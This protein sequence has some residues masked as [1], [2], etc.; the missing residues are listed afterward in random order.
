MSSSTGRGS[1]Q[2]NPQLA[3]S[4]TQKLQ[5]PGTPQRVSVTLS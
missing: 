1:N 3:L 2:S 4:Q 5:V